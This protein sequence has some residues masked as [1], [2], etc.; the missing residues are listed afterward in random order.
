[1][2]SL[3]ISLVAL[4]LVAA[5][6]AW[7]QKAPKNAE[8]RATAKTEQLNQQVTLTPEQQKAAYD[9]YLQNAQQMDADRAKYKNNVT[10]L[11]AAR[12]QNQ[13]VLDESIKKIL[14]DA[15]KAKLDKI[16]QEQKAKQ[17]QIGQLKTD[18]TKSGK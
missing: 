2:K 4:L 3:K 7:A 6:F 8:E 18:E 1:M 17:R 5:N 14:T 10:E 9:A 12:L 16:A 15:Q 13:Q 11:R